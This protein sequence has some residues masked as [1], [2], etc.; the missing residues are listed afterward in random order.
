MDVEKLAKT[1]DITISNKKLMI[2][3]FTHSSYVNEHQRKHLADNERLEFLGDAV[4]EL[5]VSDYL[6]N[7]FPHMSEGEMTKLRASIVCE[8]SL[9]NFAEILNFSQYILLGKGEERTGGRNRQALLADVFEAFLGSLYLDQGMKV[10]QSFLEQHIFPHIN[11]DAFSYVMDYK[12]KLQEVIQQ[13][14]GNTLQYAIVEEKGP[15][16]RKEF[17]A[18]VI[19]NGENRTKGKGNSKKNAEQAAAKRMLEKLS[20]EK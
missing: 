13:D 4:L 10:C 2:Q 7:K 18:E 12:T 20:Q 17:V 15:A 3:A 19:I 16:H 11:T 14:R 9:Y 5:A 6:Y 8:E 1:L